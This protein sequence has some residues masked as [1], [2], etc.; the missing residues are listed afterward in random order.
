MCNAVCTFS[1]MCLYRDI[2][3]CRVCC[4]S[5]AAG[6]VCTPPAPNATLVWR[7]TTLLSSVSPDGNSTASADG[8]CGAALAIAGRFVVV[9]CPSRNTVA[10]LARNDTT[11]AWA[12]Q[13]VLPMVT[14]ADAAANA[15][16]GGPSFTGVE[17]FGSAVFINERHLLVGASGLSQ[18]PVFAAPAGRVSG[19]G[20]PSA[21]AVFVYN[22]PL[23]AG[24]NISFGDGLQISTAGPVPSRLCVIGGDAAYGFLGYSLASDYLGD[25]ALVFAGAPNINMA[26]TV[27]IREDGAKLS[28][29][30]ISN[31]SC[32][33][34]D[35]ISGFS[36]HT[37]RDLGHAVSYNGELSFIGSPTAENSNIDPIY[38][39]G[40][41]YVKTYCFPNRC[42]R[43]ASWHG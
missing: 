7:R 30:S 19:S 10:I 24:I 13:S 18:L 26:Y 37:E 14:A 35:T 20:F 23:R 11:R 39:N 12:L 1:C 5:C 3:W 33:V 32:E 17:G 4:V 40:R 8:S 16:A 42:V 2:T 31:I 34:K 9:G 15:A 29:P 38:P 21:G 27:L 36:M 6:D 25:N 43:V 28:A 22:S 41:M